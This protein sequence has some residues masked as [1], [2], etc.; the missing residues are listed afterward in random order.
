MNP[1]LNGKSASQA[2]ELVSLM[3]IKELEEQ[4][5]A[6]RTALV[7]AFNQLLDMKDL[8]TGYHCTRLAEWALR[9]GEEFSLGEELLA[10]LEVAAMLHDIGKMGIPDAILLKPG[11]LT[12]EEYAVVKKHPEYGWAI[13]RL[14]PGFK[15]AGLIVLHHHEAHDGSGYPG[16]LKGSQIPLEARI[17]H[18]IDAFDAMVSN[19]PYRKGMPFE[20]A[21][22]QLYKCSS[23]QFDPQVV[24]CFTAIT[25]AEMTDVFAATGTS[26]SVVL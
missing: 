1:G 19:R 5:S 17:V 14:F 25:R 11:R 18:V 24:E 21:I 16:R 15:Q 6:T 20:E 9:V 26:T 3:R 2:S 12:E 4:V 7:C 23:T 13:L 22:N 8:N 10:D